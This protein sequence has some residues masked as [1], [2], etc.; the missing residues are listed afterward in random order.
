VFMPVSLFVLL[1]QVVQCLILGHYCEE[2]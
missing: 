1:G 2:N